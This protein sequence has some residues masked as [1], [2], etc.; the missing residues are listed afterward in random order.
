M[1]TAVGTDPDAVIKEFGLS[2]REDLDVLLQKGLDA[3]YEARKTRPRPHL[4]DKIVTA[5]NGLMISGLSV[6]GASLQVGKRG[7]K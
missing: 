2:G 1:L 3:L 5:W 4:D 6:A 7:F